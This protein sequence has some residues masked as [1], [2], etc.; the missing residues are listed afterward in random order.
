[1]SE[2]VKRDF[3]QEMAQSIGEIIECV[4]EWHAAKGAISTPDEGRLSLAWKKFMTVATERGIAE[5]M[6]GK[7]TAT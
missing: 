6:A 1:M 4:K 5:F 2:V 3:E 7:A